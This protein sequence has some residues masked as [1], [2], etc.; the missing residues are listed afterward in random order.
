[1]REKKITSLQ[2]DKSLLKS[3]GEDVFISSLVELKRPHLI[4]IGNHAAIDSGVYITTAAEIGDYI[5]ISPYVTVIG[6]AKS[7]LI[8]ENF[9][10]IATGTR[11]ICGSDK[12][13][14]HGFTSVTVPEKYRD[15]VDF[16]TIRIKRF[17][18]IGT[19]VVILPGVTIGEGSVVGACSLVTKDT[20]PWTVYHGIPAKAVKKRPKEKMLQY[21]KELGYIK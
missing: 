19:N 17:A 12:F 18:G 5:H 20:K 8:V 14:G 9:V 21:A 2:Y 13:M 4:S 15:K 1:M 6:G 16:T 11:I 7:K 3:F 10:T